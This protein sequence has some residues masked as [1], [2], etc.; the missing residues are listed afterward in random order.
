STLATKAWE[1]LAKND[2]EAVLAYTNKCIELYAAKA[3]EMQA[4][5]KNYV[6][7]SN[8]DIFKMW[9]LNDVATAYYIQGEAY[10]KANMKDESKEAFNKAMNEYSFGQCWDAGG[11]FWKPAD[12]AKEKLAMMEAGINLDFGDYKSNALVLKAW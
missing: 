8:D 5:L 9:A 3:K 1:A 10:R 2:I 6:T 4:G 12:A 11:W 7:G